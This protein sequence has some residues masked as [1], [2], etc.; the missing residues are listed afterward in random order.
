MN[1]NLDKIKKVQIFIRNK[2]VPNIHYFA[3]ALILIGKNKTGFETADTGVHFS[4]ERPPPL[5][6]SGKTRFSNSESILCRDMKLLL[7]F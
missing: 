4:L 2:V 6:R 5:V 7:N 1:K 3:L